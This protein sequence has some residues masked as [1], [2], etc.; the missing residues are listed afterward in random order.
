MKFDSIGLTSLRRRDLLVTACLPFAAAAVAS[1]KIGGSPIL[2]SEF[3]DP[4]PTFP[5]CHASTIVELPD[6]TL[7]AAWFGGTEEGAT[8]VSI[9]FAGRGLQAWDK[10][11]AVADGR[12]PGPDRF[13][14]KSAR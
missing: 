2:L 13:A 6:G 5:Q 1:A 4:A 14:S 7:A 11:F 12:L 8:D 9:W 3:V 10:P